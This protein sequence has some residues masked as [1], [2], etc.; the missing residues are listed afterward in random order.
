[1]A[2]NDKSSAAAEKFMADIN[3]DASEKNTANNTIYDKAETVKATAGMAN[4]EFDIFSD[5]KDMSNLNYRPKVQVQNDVDDYGKPI[6]WP[7]YSHFISV[8]FYH[9]DKLIKSYQWWI[10]DVF[11]K[12]YNKPWDANRPQVNDYA[13]MKPD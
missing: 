5:L 7:P 8:P 11:E 12:L 6:K 9:S 3:A 2:K 10:A 1:M 4:R 13:F